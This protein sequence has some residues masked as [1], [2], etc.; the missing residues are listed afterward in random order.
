MD[1]VLPVLR[2]ATAADLE[3]I[4]ELYDQD[5]FHARD[6]T[7]H[8]TLD[9]ALEAFRELEANL[10]N[11]VFV[12]E[13]DRRIVGTFQI[14]FIRQLNFRGCRVA[15]IE[16]VQVAASMRSRGIGRSM[17][18]WAIEEARRR[19]CIRLQLTSSKRREHAHRFY[20]QLGFVRSHEGMKLYLD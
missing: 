19:G 1:R 3:S 13:V 18:Q 12:A 5:E 17:I 16:S 4:L 15:Q 6:A 11:A 9:Q 20:E 10:D 7:G 2:R 14:T 8:S